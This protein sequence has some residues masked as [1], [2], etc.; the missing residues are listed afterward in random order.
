MDQLE[1]AP[2][3]A[4]SSRLRVPLKKE[5]KD[6]EKRF[7]GYSIVK[8]SGWS[9]WRLILASWKVAYRHALVTANERPHSLILHTSSRTY[10][11][12]SLHDLLVA[13][14]R[15]MSSSCSLECQ[16]TFILLKI[17]LNKATILF[18]LFTF[19]RHS[20]IQLKS[21]AKWLRDILD[22]LSSICVACY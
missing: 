4:S 2:V 10:K 8:T 13:H 16:R 21:V 5:E 7:L 15:F 3:H 12:Q 18:L 6:E 11:N 1:W 22:P 14:G 20:Y 17:A 19:S 9:S